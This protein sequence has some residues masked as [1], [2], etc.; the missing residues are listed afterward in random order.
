MKFEVLYILIFVLLFIGVTALILTANDKYE[1]IFKFDFSPKKIVAVQ[2]TT[3]QDTTKIQLD[4]TIQDDLKLD[5]LK[6][7]ALVDTL[8]EGEKNN[9]SEEEFAT[10]K[11]FTSDSAY[12][13]WKKETVKLYESMDSKKVA[14]IFENLSD[15][16]ARDLIYSM[17]KKKAAEILSNVSQEL[18]I[19]LT[20]VK[21]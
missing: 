18:A 5:S 11:D 17:K 21:R 1:N 6:K 2:D 14:K 3:K 20:R 15:D 9:T 10:E 12:I 8:K 7:A 13:K 19:R 16:V 4:S